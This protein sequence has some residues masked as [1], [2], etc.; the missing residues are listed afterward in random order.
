MR[1]CVD[2]QNLNAVVV[3]DSY[4]VP[5]MDEMIDIQEAV[6]VLTTLDANSRYLKIKIPRENRD[7]TAFNCHAGLERSLCMPFGL[8]NAPASFQ[9]AL[10]IMLSNDKWITALAYLDDVIINSRRVKKHLDHNGTV[11]RLLMEAGVSLKLRRCTYFEE[12]V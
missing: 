10:D 4:P 9:R 2:Y 12:R 3:R 1:F 6:K 7:K 8:K 5:R 11:L